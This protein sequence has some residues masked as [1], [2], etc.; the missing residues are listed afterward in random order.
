MFY[1]LYEVNSYKGDY[2]SRVKLHFNSKYYKNS[3]EIS[4]LFGLTNSIFEL[5][6][7]YEGLTMIRNELVHNCFISP[8]PQIYR[9]NGTSQVN[10]NDI[11]YI[12]CF[13]WD[14][15]DNK[16]ITYL[17]R[18]RFFSQQNQVDSYLLN[19]YL[20]LM[21]DIDYSINELLIFLENNAT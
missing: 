21:E 5:S 19:Q 10:N 6:D 13:M 2:Y 12:S 4:K 11:D 3:K 8:I 7:K 9:G 14:L 17:N 1:A 16:P 18:R 20:I 15:E